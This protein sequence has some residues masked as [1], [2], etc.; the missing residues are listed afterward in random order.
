MRYAIAIIGLLAAC[1]DTAAPPPPPPP[2]PMIVKLVMAADTGFYR[3]QRLSLAHLIRAAV[4]DHGDTVAAPATVT[5]TIPSGFVR[6][7]DS[8]RAT[9]EV[10]GGLRASVDGAVDSTATIAVTDLA[11][12]SWAITSRCYNNPSS[13]R[14]VENPPIGL[15]S[16]FRYSTS[17]TLAYQAGDWKDRRATLTVQSGAIRFWKDGLVDTVSGV[18]A[19]PVTQD[20]ARAAIAVPSVENFKMEADSP[21][22]YRATWGAGSTWCHDFIGGGSDFI[23][24]EP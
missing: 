5:W 8:V 3:G 15:D 7:G 13:I 14:D 24:K 1:K 23:L 9:R 16:V 12:R 21:R 19:Y 17:G 18:D 11:A 22:V 20:T 6:E 2:P 4:T 10:R